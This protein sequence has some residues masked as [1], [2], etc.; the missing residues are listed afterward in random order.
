MD[1]A[2]ELQ[3]GSL[4]PPCVIQGYPAAHRHY[5]LPIDAN[6]L[7]PEIAFQRKRHHGGVFVND[8]S[9]E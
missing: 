1:T 2:F 9:E 5:V 6:L 4:L 8:R 3:P 7:R